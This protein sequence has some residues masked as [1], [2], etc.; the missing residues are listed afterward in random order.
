M[1]KKYTEESLSELFQQVET[2]D[3][4]FFS[5]LKEEMLVKDSVELNRKQG[6]VMYYFIRTFS[7]VVALLLLVIGVSVYLQSQTNPP[8]QL[9]EQYA[10][11]MVEDV[12]DG[13]EDLYAIEYD[14]QSEGVI[15][16]DVVDFYLYE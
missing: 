2:E 9:Q 8:S 14:E 16:D 10:Q 5:A 11:L 15:D 6:P 3:L 4:Q 12:V 1:T 7:G 13:D